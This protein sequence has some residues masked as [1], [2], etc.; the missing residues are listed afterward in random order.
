MLPLSSPGKAE[1]LREGDPGVA[2]SLWIPFPSLRSAGD[3]RRAIR[4][5]KCD[6]AAGF[7]GPCR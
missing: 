5:A 3:D 4:W 2:A 1:G 6:T 7:W